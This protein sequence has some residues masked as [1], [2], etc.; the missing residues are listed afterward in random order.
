MAWRRVL[1][2]SKMASFPVNCVSQL[3]SELKGTQ[4][5]HPAIVLGQSIHCVIGMDDLAKHRP[6]AVREES[7]PVRGFPAIECST[8]DC[9]LARK[10]INRC[11]RAPWGSLLWV[12]VQR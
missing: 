3:P 6:P 11:V 10:G 9:L 12:L 2:N 7:Q 4:S 8:F 1:C 5:E